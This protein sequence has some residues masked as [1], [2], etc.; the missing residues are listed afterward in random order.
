[1]RRDPTD[2]TLQGD[3]FGDLQPGRL[4]D[5]CRVCA[6]FARIASPREV[7]STSTDQLRHRDVEALVSA[8]GGL[9]EFS[10][11]FDFFVFLLLSFLTL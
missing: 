4:A 1:M 8:A 10:A 11:A 9:A 6:T 2:L 7:S 3:E 5:A